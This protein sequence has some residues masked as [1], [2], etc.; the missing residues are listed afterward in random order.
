MQAPTAIRVADEPIIE[1]SAVPGY[2]AVFNAGLL[3]HDGAYHLFARGVRDGY[4]HNGGPGP[5][6]VDYLSDVL[7]FSS[8]DGR[9]YEFQCV[10][11]AADTCFSYE[12]P[13]VQRVRSGDVEHIVMTY[14]RFPDP[15][16]K[17]PWRIGFDRLRYAGG[18]FELAGDYGRVIGP[19]GLENKDAV[20][21]NLRD[22]RVALIHRL[23][24]DMQLAVFDTLEDLL[25][26][27]ETFWNSHLADLDK[28]TILRPAP[29][30]LGIGAGA[31]PVATGPGLLLFFHERT[32]T[33]AYTVNVALLDHDTGR[34]A[35]QLHE[36]ILLPEQPWER[37]GDVD[38]V[39]FVVGA[40]RHADGEIY[41]TY[42]AAD[43]VVG[44]ATV[45]ERD[46]LGALGVPATE[47]PR[48]AVS[49]L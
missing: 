2:G 27:D 47:Y 8:N 40:H 38:N 12:D 1:P 4:R 3:H 48:E 24:P 33:G 37:R 36:P 5:R 35:A 31:P 26:G 25:R 44:A 49:L 29:G 46:L 10:L 11:A 42:G 39:V 19:A 28:H 34:V 18:R 14:T 9:H 7:H 17:E 23:H 45:H 21:F 6:F 20:L 22:G 43:R 15:S 13:R 41:L 32:A 30:V 16:R